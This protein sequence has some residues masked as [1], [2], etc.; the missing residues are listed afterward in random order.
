[1]KINSKR[2]TAIILSVVLAFTCFMTQSMAA[3]IYKVNLT[4]KFG[5]TEARTMLSMINNF[6]KGSDAWYWNESNTQ[7]VKCSGLGTLAYDYELEK[8][9]MQRAAELAVYYDHTRPNGQVCFTAYDTGLAAGENIAIGMNSFGNASSVF[10]AWQ[11]TNDKYSGQGHRRNMLSENFGAVAVGFATYN[12]ITCW[13]QEF[14][15]EPISAK[16]TTANDKNTVVPIDILS[17]NITEKKVTPS[18]NTITLDTGKNASASLPTVSAYIVTKES[19]VS[20]VTVNVPCTWS[21]SDEKVA[22]ISDG[23]VVAVGNGKAT[24]TADALGE[25]A[26]VTVTVAGAAAEKMGDLNNDGSVNSS[27]ALMVLQ[28]S[29]GQLKLSDA[30][31]AAADIDKNGAVNSSDALKILQFSVGAIK[32]L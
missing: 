27:D 26:S 20:G 13:V 8:A 6:R 19:F 9:A 32:S 29:V 23:K 2:I 15:N 31:K 30:Q 18:V 22:K 10:T 4:V 5:Q 25:K 28:C 1:M 12:N 21:S 11:E 17:T 7:K 16:Q 3:E 14:R 24:L